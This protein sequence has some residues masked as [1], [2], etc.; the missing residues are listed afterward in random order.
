M[1]RILLFPL[2]SLIFSIPQATLAQSARSA[3]PFAKRAH[4]EG[5]RVAFSALTDGN[6]AMLRW[7]IGSDTAVIGFNV[8]RLTANGFQPVN[9]ALIAGP[10]MKNGVEDAEGSEFQYFDKEGA[11]GTAY[12]YETIFLNGSRSRSQTT[13]AV[14]D[15][16]LSGEFERAAAPYRLARAVSPADLA[17][18]DLD[19]PRVL[20][21][22]MLSS[23]PKPNVRMQRRL[24]ILDGAKI[25]IKKTGFYRVTANELS[26]VDF[27]VSSDP[28]TWQL[29]V[30]GNEVA[31]NVDP[32]GQFI[33]FFGR[34]IDTVETNTRIY[35]LTSGLGIGKR[36]SRRSLRPLGGNVTAP[37]YD[38]TFESVERKQYINTILNGDAENWWGRMVSNSPTSYTFTLSGVDPTL[39]NLPIRIAL[40][41]FT[42]Q[43]HSISLKING[44]T[45]GNATGSG[46]I[47][48]VF[49]G[50]IP[51]AFLVN[52]VNTL[53]MT[54]G[55]M[56]DISMFDGIRI[57]YP[58]NYVAANGR[59]EFYTHNYKRSTVT[60]FA[61]SSIRLFDIT[62]ES[63]VAEYSNLN[64]VAGGNGFDLKLPAARGRVLYSIDPSAV[65]SPYSLAPNFPS[66]LRNTAN[67]A[68]MVIIYYRPYEQQ[69]QDWAAFRQSQGVAVR[70]VDADDIY[71]EFSFGLKN[72]EAIN[73]F[74][75]YA[76]QNWATPPNYAL[77]L[78]GASENPKDYD[79]SPDDQGYN[80]DVP[81][82]LVNT[83]YTETGSDEAMGD[84]NEDG[85]SEIAIGRIPGRTTED[86]Q[87]ALD[88]TI[89]WENGVRSLS[90]GT[91]FA[92]DLPDGYDFQAMSGRIRNN[93]PSG[94]A[95]DM[96]GR[97]DVDAHTALMTSMNTGKYLVNYAG[98]GTIGIWASSAFFGSPH[99]AQLT[100]ST[101]PSTYTLLTCL[102]GYFLNLYGY[103]L[104]E[105]LLEWPDRG[106]AAVWASTGKTTPDVQEVMA[107]RF[108]LKVGD[109]S[110]L[111]IGDLILDAKQQ[112]PNAHDVRVSWILMGDP[113]LRM[114]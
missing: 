106:A 69:A 40:Q 67:A 47:P 105:N 25:G 26:N 71:D 43:P 2:I 13:T 70:L 44:N 24:C 29:F 102:N 38:Q 27:D 87:A 108:Y 20:R 37:R 81:T 84:F 111:R 23:I 7:G 97:G 41:G 17:K 46:Q 103:S 85:L 66:D 50:T 34:G 11:P 53:E 62:N 88:K 55:S 76:K 19:L 90:R 58:R 107:T 65:E 73:R 94:T 109:G 63:E 74:F 56:S 6:G 114:H 18:S 45:L 30:D 12:F 21:D 112:L 31:M 49:N 99:V 42:L 80:N 92:Y 3:L 35:Y 33:E 36:F 82:R 32:A 4:V 98:H 54:S 79:L 48:L 59:V 83:V 75:R 28:T 96:V 64:I 1:R 68:D 10:A 86:I 8:F 51:A 5:E 52:G 15:A 60:G 104:S 77:I 22:E 93:L 78:G 110:I 89:V 113:M 91:L 100:N 39:T 101:A 72:W 14:Y 95:A 16:S 57:S 9:D 61:T